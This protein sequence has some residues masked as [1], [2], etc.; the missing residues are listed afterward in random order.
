MGCAMSPVSQPHKSHE[1]V[2]S[3][4]GGIDWGEISKDV[5]KQSGGAV[6]AAPIRLFYG[7]HHAANKGFGKTHIEAEHS[8]EFAICGFDKFVSDAVSYF[9][10]IYDQNGKRTVLFRSGRARL[11]AV[12]ELRNDGVNAFYSIITAYR[13]NPLKQIQGNVVW[14]NK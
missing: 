10:T 1:H 13:A 2:P 6:V 8:E 5:E 3:P 7:R 9:D 14:K 4:S 12:L 11:V